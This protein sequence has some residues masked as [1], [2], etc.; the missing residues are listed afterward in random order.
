MSRKTTSKRSE[1][2]VDDNI[3]DEIIE[4][5]IPEDSQ[6]LT[7][8]IVEESIVKN[9]HSQS[10]VED[11]IIREEYDNVPANTSKGIQA[12]QKQRFGLL[13]VQN[14]AEIAKE[15]NLSKGM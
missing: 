7:D 15:S 6:A 11:S 13:N 3:V 14:P 10:I 2:K 12:R 5:S 9:S 4:E 8:S 1:P